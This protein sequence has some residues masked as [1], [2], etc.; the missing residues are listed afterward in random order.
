MHGR[1]EDSDDQW[2]QR[3]HDLLLLTVDTHWS[4][5]LMRHTLTS[6]HAERVHTPTAQSRMRVV[7][8]HMTVIMRWIS[9]IHSELRLKFGAG[10]VQK[11]SA[12][13]SHHPPTCCAC[14]NATVASHST[15]FSS[16]THLTTRSHE[17]WGRE[18][19]SLYTMNSEPVGEAVA[20]VQWNSSWI[21]HESHCTKK[22]HP[23]HPKHQQFWQLTRALLT[24]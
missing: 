10:T 22:T 6:E 13:C 19:G 4:G 3:T 9:A 12:I 17:S 14:R 20:N 8:T 5:Q 23:P 7:W 18:R 2:L 1:T 21:C 15:A 24:N 11:C 16:T